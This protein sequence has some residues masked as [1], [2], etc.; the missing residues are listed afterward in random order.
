MTIEV[1]FFVMVFVASVINSSV[2]ESTDEVAS[3]SIKMD[4]LYT[5]A[6]MKDI[7]PAKLQRLIVGR[8]NH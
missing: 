1:R 2:S 8:Q 6:R 4:G 5:N 3:S 7:V